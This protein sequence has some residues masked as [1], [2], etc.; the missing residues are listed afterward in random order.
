M[1]KI[2]SS[3]YVV[4][5]LI[6][7]ALRFFPIFPSSKALWILQL[8]VSELGLI[9]AA[10]LLIM[11]LRLWRR[12]QKFRL[13]AVLAPIALV[14]CVLPIFETIGQ[15]RNW[16]WDLEYG[17]GRDQ[18]PD[19]GISPYIGELRRPLFQLKDFFKVPSFP[20]A[21]DEYYPVTDGSKHAV[22]IYHPDGAPT[23]AAGRPWVMSIHGGGWSSGYPTDLSQ[24]VSALLEKGF[25]VVAPK[26]RFAPTYPWPTQQNDLENAYRYVIANAARLKIDPTQ[27]WLMGRSAGGQLALKLAYGSGVVKNVK[28]VIALYAP[29]DLDFGYRWSLEDDVL[30]SRKMLRELVGSTPDESPEKY[31]SA[32]PLNDVKP[33]SPPTLILSGR[34]D[35]LVWYRHAHRL[36]DRLK[37][38]R[39]RVVHLELPWATH[40]F[41]YFPGSPGGQVSTN[42]IL[43]FLEAP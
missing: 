9:F 41:D 11:T 3:V 6:G 8:L 22:F 4:I 43:R 13:A 2:I 15:E 40:G 27:L 31:R 16:I 18:K 19:R 34:A 1:L 28:G 23:S 20:T 12:P 39:V 5:L 42:A 33:T 24:T 25:V 30:N 38:N 21:Q 35:P 17:S 26:Y 7:G 10:P 14:L 29:T 37:E 32:S 36:A